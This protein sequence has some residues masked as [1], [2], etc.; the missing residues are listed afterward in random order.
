MRR[1]AKEDM[2]EGG[3][4]AYRLEYCYLICNPI[5][6]LEYRD[7]SKRFA[8]ECYAPYSSIGRS[9]IGENG[10]ARAVTQK[11]DLASW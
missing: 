5:G 1:G 2:V 4:H 3:I 7:K 11:E 10:T 8:I 6:K 9:C